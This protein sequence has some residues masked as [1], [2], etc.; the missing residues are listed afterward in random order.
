M[1]PAAIAARIRRLEQL[2]LGVARELQIEKQTDIFLWRERLEYRYVL[3]AAWNGFENARVVL[4]KARQRL[5]GN[6]P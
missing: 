1:S 2:A 4:A 3:L 5:E 6:G